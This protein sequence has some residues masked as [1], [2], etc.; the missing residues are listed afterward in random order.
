MDILRNQAGRAA[1]SIA[2]A[3]VHTGLGRDAIYDAIRSGK[4]V[5]RNFGRRTL[6][7]ETDLHRFLTSLPKAGAGRISR[8]ETTLSPPK[9]EM[10]RVN[11]RGLAGTSVR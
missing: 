5:A 6:I 2:A 8:R 1:L 4:L 11:S 9:T 7:V 3:S 10:P